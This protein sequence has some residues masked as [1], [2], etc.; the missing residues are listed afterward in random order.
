MVVLKSKRSKGRIA[1]AIFAVAGSLLVNSTVAMAA[2]KTKQI[3]VAYLSFA[4]TNS[5][6]APMLAAARAVAAT[7][8][9]KVTV[10][11]AGNDPKVQYS[12]L[13][14]AISSRKYQGIITQ[15]IFG[16]GLA[17]LVA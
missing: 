2:Q 14:N 8:G 16:A 3:N 7:A 11:D 17:P 13:Q 9:V 6:D 4:I 10:F 15:P 1:F 5:Y 12:Q